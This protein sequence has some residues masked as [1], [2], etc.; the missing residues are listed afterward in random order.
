MVIRVFRDAT[1]TARAE[2]AA[3]AADALSAT[4]AVTVVAVACEAA[5]NAV[6]PF[7]EKV[8][9]PAVTGA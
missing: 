7:A 9:E 3:S 1:V 2:T 4:V 5:P 6:P 8:N